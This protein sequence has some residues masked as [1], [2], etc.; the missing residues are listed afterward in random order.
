MGKILLRGFLGIAP[1]AITLLLI[2]WLY[3]KIN[4][5]FSAPI[6]YLIGNKYYFD[7]IG[8]IIA[9][10]FLFLMGLV[11]NNWMIQHLYNCF[12]RI[13]K[14]IPLLKT[15]YTSISDLMSF[16]GAGQKQQKGRVVMVQLGGIKMLGLVTREV[17]DDL[18]N[19][20]GSKDDV[21][22]FFP[23]SY[24]IGGFTAVVP[25]FM[26]QTVDLSIERGL[27]FVVTAGNPSADKPTFSPNKR[28]K[29]EKHS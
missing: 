18:P 8:I 22:V 5:L 1:I 26:I 16:F 3:E 27:R 29:K 19:G 14:K 24:Q 20:V 4:D 13:L 15:I 7:G 28:S 21:V 17:F 10:V 9:F 25:K 2:I 12:E 23:S 11:L 6:H